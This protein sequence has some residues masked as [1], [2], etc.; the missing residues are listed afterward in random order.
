MRPDDMPYVVKASAIGAVPLAGFL[1]PSNAYRSCTLEFYLSLAVVL[2]TSVLGHSQAP[3]N[4]GYPIV[5]KHGGGSTNFTQSPLVIDVTQYGNSDVCADISAALL[6]MP[7]AGNP[8]GEWVLDARGGTDTTNGQ[9]HYLTCQGNPFAASTG[10]PINKSFKLLLGGQTYTACVPWTTPQLPHVIEGIGIQAK[11]PHNTVIKAGLGGSN[12]SCSGTFPNSQSQMD[13][14]WAHGQVP[15]GT[16]SAVIVDGGPVLI[17]QPGGHG[18]PTTR[19]AFGSRI[20]DLTI[21]TNGIANVLGYYSANEEEQ[22]VVERVTFQNLGTTTNNLSIGLFWDRGFQTSANT[23]NAPPGTGASALA[24]VSGGQV[25]ACNVSLVAG[26]NYAMPPEVMFVGS[27]G[28][29]TNA[30]PASGYNALAHA[31]INSSNQVSG[32]VLDYRGAGYTSAPNVLFCP[33]FGGSG[34]THMNTRLTEFDTGS[35]AADHSA[36]GLYYYGFATSIV[37]SGGGCTKV[38]LAYPTLSNG[39][40]TGGI[41]TYPGVGCGNPN[42]NINAYSAPGVLPGTLGKGSPATCHTTGNGTTIVIDNQGSDYP[43]NNL[44]AAGREIGLITVQGQQSQAAFVDGIGVDGDYNVWIHDIHCEYIRDCV[45][46]GYGGTSYSLGK[47]ERIDQGNTMT[48]SLV[49][50]GSGGDALGVNESMQLTGQAGTVLQDDE[51]IIAGLPAVSISFATAGRNGLSLYCPSCVQKGTCTLSSISPF[52]CT[53]TFYPAF[54]NTP[55]CT[56]NDQTNAAQVK[57]AP[58]AT[59]ATF[60]GG[61]GAAAGDTV[62]YQCLPNPN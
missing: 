48:G 24:T 40:V 35:G 15:V 55:V 57:A 56:A 46:R 32:C 62:A 59:G 21:D 52:Q 31:T 13:F 16:Y 29:C 10:G 41:I 6:A 53:V 37:L 12:D 44:Q 8:G 39:H 36:Y 17:S 23:D 45:H 54:S 19:D 25:T 4:Q 9:T 1:R 49:H 26:T 27:G 22:S 60:I 38:P 18:V 33:V 42:C 30:V 58:S 61:S 3:T 5:E 7:G 34:P 51:P 47:V 11:H 2:A 20:S 43:E 50:L 28:T 14:Q